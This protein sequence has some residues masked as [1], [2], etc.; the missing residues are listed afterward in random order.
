[1][2]SKNFLLL[3]SC[4]LLLTLLTPGCLKS[5]SYVRSFDYKENQKAKFLFDQ[6]LAFKENG[7]Y[8]EA[9]IEFQHF[10]DYYQDLHGADEALFHIG[11][12]YQALGQWNEA[13]NA[14]RA[15]EKK[16]PHS[17]LLP[18]LM[19]NRGECY[20][21]LS[22]WDEAVLSYA[23][24]IEKYFQTEDSEK[25]QDRLVE[26]IKKFPSGKGA[27]KAA[28]RINKKFSY[29]KYPSFDFAPRILF[30]QAE[31]LEKE[32]QSKEAVDQYTNIVGDY[33]QTKWKDS[34]IE[35][36]NHILDKFKDTK[37]AEKKRKKLDKTIGKQE[38]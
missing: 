24:V 22:N 25:A 23:R 14:C 33:Y 29:K 6:G 19:L 9:V 27:K 30:V 28:K 34:A 32:M 18:K 4:F 1:M 35:R 17:R 16:F 31:A 8:E 2:K 13:V 3:T 15:L 12:S 11:E 21:E 26:L 37:W 38:K 36:I 5:K 10:L 7:Q 20:E